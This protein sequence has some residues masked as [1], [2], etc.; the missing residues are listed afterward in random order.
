MNIAAVIVTYN[1]KDKLLKNIKCLLSQ[2]RELNKIYIIDNASTDNTEE[3]IIPLAEQYENI[4]YIRLEENLGGSGG[5]SAGIKLAFDN[6]HDYIWGMDDD[7]FPE[8]NALEKLIN[9]NIENRDTTCLWSNCNNDFEGYNLSGIKEVYNWMFVGFFLPKEIISKVGIPRNDFFIYHDDTEYAERIIKHGFKIYKVKDSII[10]HGDLASREFFS[11]KI[12]SITINFPKMPDW[13]LYYYIRNS[14][15]KHSY[16]EMKKYKY[17][18]YYIPKDILKI[19]LLNRKQL[20]IILT[21]YLD[22]IRGV[23]G[24]K[25]F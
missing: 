24:K 12:G 14:L 18:L 6:N 25:E 2:T 4:E 1:R 21:A 3:V 20:K 19:L 8:Y 13:K 17:L 23:S 10:D 11:K 15:L 7:A 5:F 9:I 16:K 22:G